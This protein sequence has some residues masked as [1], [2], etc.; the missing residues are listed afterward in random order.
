MGRYWFVTPDDTELIQI[1]R[2]WFA[3][4]WRKIRKD[5]QY[6]SFESVYTEFKAD[7]QHLVDFIAEADLGRFSPTQ[8][9][10]SYI[11]HIDR[12]G[13][14]KSHGDATEVFSILRK[15]EERVPPAARPH[16]ALV[17]QITLNGW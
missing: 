17:R 4:N 16:Y 11:N 6:P 9:E 10:V 2:D 15:Q 13:P 8:C 3:R 1:Q 7:L 14:W 12:R 5:V